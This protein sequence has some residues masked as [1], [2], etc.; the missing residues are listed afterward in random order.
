MDL[1]LEGIQV[2]VFLRFSW[3]YYVRGE[4]APTFNI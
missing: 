4:K 1:K 3:V 2:A